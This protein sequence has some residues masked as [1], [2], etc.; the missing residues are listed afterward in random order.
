MK[1][2]LLFIFFSVSLLADELLYYYVSNKTMGHAYFDILNGIVALINNELYVSILKFVFTIGGFMVFLMGILKVLQGGD[3]KTPITEFT[4]YMI[5]GTVVLTL[6]YSGST[7]DMAVISETLS[8]DVCNSSSSSAVDTQDYSAFTVSMPEILAY[9]F[10][11]INNIG[12]ELTYMSTSVYSSLTDN[13]IIEDSLRQTSMD[14]IGSQ[15]EGLQG[16]LS[17]R[18]DDLFSVDAAI[19]GG[20]VAPLIIGG[21]GQFGTGYSTK[22]SIG[23]F[24]KTFFTQCVFMTA[25]SES[26]SHAKIQNALKSTTNLKHLLK[27]L[28]SSDTDGEI[29]VSYYSTSGESNFFK[30]ILFGDGSVSDPTIPDQTIT[31]QN[32]GS[33]PINAFGKHGNCNQYYND[34]IHPILYANDNR[35]ACA[36][37]IGK[38]ITPSSLYLLTGDSQ[39]ATATK[40]SDIIMNSAVTN[41]LQESSAD[42]R[43]SSD[44]A[45]ASG[46]STAEFIMNNTGTGIYMAKMIPY[47]QMGIRAILYAFFP[48]VF[49]VILFPGGFS[50]LKS[51]GESVLWVELWSPVAAVLNMFMSYFQIDTINEHYS[52]GMNYSTSLNIAT[53]ANMLAA[54][55]GYLYM[56]VPAL[57]W[58]VLKGSAQMLGSISGGMASNFA[59]NISSDTVMRDAEK[60]KTKEE[61]EK[62]RPGENVDYSTI[63]Y[64]QASGRGAQAG[65]NM[66]YLQNGGGYI[67]QMGMS[68]QRDAQNI[69]SSNHRFDA[70]ATMNHNDIDAMT[71][72]DTL[73]DVQALHGSKEFIEKY[74]QS[75]GLTGEDGKVKAGKEYLKQVS[76]IAQETGQIL[77][78]TEAVEEVTKEA[79][80]RMLG[81]N[82]SALRP[83]EGAKG[84][85]RQIREI[86]GKTVPLNDISKNDDGSFSYNGEAGNFVSNED[87]FL[88]N[89]QNAD[90]S[91]GGFATVDLSSDYG[92]KVLNNVRAYAKGKSYDDVQAALASNERRKVLGDK[93]YIYDGAKSIGEAKEYITSM[94]EGGSAEA[95]LNFLKKDLEAAG[96]K[97]GVKE[98]D[99]TLKHIKNGNVT[100]AAAGLARISGKYK[101]STE[102][103]DNQTQQV[104]KRMEQASGF[105]AQDKAGMSVVETA[106]RLATQ[107]GQIEGA[108]EIAKIFSDSGHDKENMAKAHELLSSENKNEQLQGL[109]MVVSKFAKDNTLASNFDTAKT[110]DVVR[111]LSSRGFSVKDLSN[112]ELNEQVMNISKQNSM[113]GA[114]D[115]NKESR[116][117][118][119]R[120]FAG[121]KDYKEEMLR[122]VNEHL[123]ASGQEEL[124]SYDEIKDN[125]TA[126]SVEQSLRR[127]AAAEVLGELS[128]ENDAWTT[129]SSNAAIES[130]KKAGFT[131]KDAGD[132][133][134]F[135][136]QEQIATQKAFVATLGTLGVSEENVPKVLGAMNVA[137]K[138]VAMAR[139][140]S[141]AMSA[142]KFGIKEP[143][144]AL[145]ALTAIAAFGTAVK[146]K[147]EIIDVLSGEDMSEELHQ[148]LSKLNNEERSQVVS[149]IVENLDEETKDKLKAQK[150]G[151]DTFK[152][153]K[154]ED[155]M[156]M[157]VGSKL[158]SQNK[159]EE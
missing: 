91:G 53:D 17:T 110:A 51:Y 54:V 138:G 113:L 127:T 88:R 8:Y 146:N 153:F 114:L 15:L 32:P 92:K 124:S 82:S 64:M 119:D 115:N 79:K 81:I 128:G 155:Y 125:D 21:S 43:L 1:L 106:G 159:K 2:L 143:V 35:V 39:A 152:N 103:S 73:K 145:T 7:R 99:K 140:G 29:T 122:T 26:E 75:H 16:L 13:P 132:A 150:E 60:I 42:A 27:E 65:A 70:L 10:S 4:K 52:Q 57:T 12:R 133:Q 157:V 83:G 55:A 48:F 68:G 158:F 72:Q 96:D 5:A 49:V 118:V 62:G 135:Q 134:S 120:K 139:I 109:G 71:A 36:G 22:G 107:D 59:K 3:A 130:L 94:G 154:D 148:D 18:L 131:A 84:M 58:L 11:S 116:E 69:V 105:Y 44:I 101:K 74:M 100:K 111:G 117:M 34:F 102:I 31:V 14:G 30:N 147:D 129:Q 141:M 142:G 136:Q 40:M 37:S 87:Q 46:R 23:G 63:E 61:Y 144:K 33:F 121:D 25:A 24:F 28:Y 80:L 56:S 76:T 50:V 90:G 67:N 85:Q 41:A 97:E 95:D 45:Y 20:E 126:K 77:G 151:D 93:Q 104:I 123:T 86:T 112:K 19:G 156:A 6:L 149:T 78:T 66:A 89:A 137:T 108:K 47:L 9:A 98:I 38:N